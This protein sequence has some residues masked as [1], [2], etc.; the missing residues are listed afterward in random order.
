MHE[1]SHAVRPP[2]LAC[3]CWSTAVVAGFPAPCG[4]NSVPRSVLLRRTRT[5]TPAE[6]EADHAADETPDAD[7]QA[8]GHEGMP[9]DLQRRLGGAVFDGVTA[10]HNGPPDVPDVLFQCFQRGL[11]E[12]S[13]CLG[14]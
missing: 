4:E 13:D 7:R 3:Q 9:P 2:E 11:R 5:A 8:N 12:L 14:R 6:G 1:L 10:G